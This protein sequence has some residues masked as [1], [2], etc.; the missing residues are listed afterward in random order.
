VIAGIVVLAGLTVLL[1]LCGGGLFLFGARSVAVPAPASDPVMP[2]PA[3]IEVE[4]EPEPKLE[5]QPA[6]RDDSP[7][8]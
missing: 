7:M 3:M 1:V 2:A 8:P 4:S 5:R 6:E